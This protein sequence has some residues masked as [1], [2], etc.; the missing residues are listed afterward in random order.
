MEEARLAVDQ[1]VELVGRA[2][3]EAVLVLSARGVAGPKQRGKARGEM[4]C[5]LRQAGKVCMSKRKVRVARP[6]LRR[7]GMSNTEEE[8]VDEDA[9][10]HRS[11]DD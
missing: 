5:H 8:W 3:I 6:R 11:P 1:L 4:R 10:S 2:A 9:T 7:K